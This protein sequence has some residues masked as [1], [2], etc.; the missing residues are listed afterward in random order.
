MVSHFTKKQKGK[1]IKNGLF[2]AISIFLAV[3]LVFLVFADIKI[4]KN[5]KKLNS[6][7]KEYQRQIEEIKKSNEEMEEGI[8]MADDREYIEKIAREEFSMQ[9]P[10]EKVVAFLTPEREEEP[11]PPDNDNF[12]NRNF[13]LKWVNN[14]WK[15][16]IE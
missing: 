16:V 7:L 9:Q 11:Q 6:Q 4:Y 13:F 1:T 15:S 2:Q 5:K 12:W 8:A 10:G 14:M 3:I